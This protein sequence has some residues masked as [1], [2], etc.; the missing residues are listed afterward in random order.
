MTIPSPVQWSRFPGPPH[1]S[2]DEVPLA[3]A[4]LLAVTDE[5]S[6]DAAYNRMLFAVGNNHAG[7][8][9]PASVA[10][11]YEVVRAALERTAWVRHCAL[12]ILIEMVCF[13]PEPGFEPFRTHDGRE[14]DV[15]AEIRKCVMAAVEAVNAIVLDQA[16]LSG[17]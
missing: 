10:A 14:V 16:S 17:T 5:A 13:A 1:Y 15:E 8:L 6:S 9:Y 12:N 3:F 7:P 11:V 4:E 2:P